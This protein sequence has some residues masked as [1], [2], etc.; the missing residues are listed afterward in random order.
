M[1]IRCILIDDE[2]PAIR[3]LE[4]LLADIPEIEI[5]DTIPLPEK[6]LAQIRKKKPDLLFLDIQMPGI[7]GFSLAKKLKENSLFPGIIFVTGH[8]EFAIQAI[9]HSAFD[10]LPKP[11]DQSDLKEAIHRFQLEKKE[12]SIPEQESQFTRQIE[13]LLARVSGQ[14]KLK[15]S[16]TSGFILID[17]DD[18]LYLQADW[19]YTELH[20]NSS[21]KEL[22]TQ[23]LGL[24]ET[25]LPSAG[26][27]RISRSIIINTAYL[28][29]VNRKKRSAVLIKEGQEYSFKIPLLNIRKLERFLEG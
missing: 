5:V 22:I 27:F 23:N 8:D 17:P 14:Q 16:T 26:F 21:K 25:V 28:T 19:N 11:V 6:A 1:T 15:F 2:V 10:F 20:Y 24:V 4:K 29:K 9:R 12:K 13:T 18:I 7:D 3:N